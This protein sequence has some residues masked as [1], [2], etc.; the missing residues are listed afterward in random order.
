[1]REKPIIAI[2]GPPGSGKTTVSKMVANKLGYRLIDTGSM[3]RAAALVAMREG[4]EFTDSPELSKRLGRMEI[5]FRVGAEGQRIIVDGEDMEDQLRSEEVGMK[6]S[7]ISRVQMVRQI[8]VEKQQ[9][10]GASGGVICEG[11]DATTV[12]F[13]DAE[14][15]FFIDAS[16]Y[17]RAERRHRELVTAGESLSFREAYED[18][19]RRDIQDSTRDNSPLKIAPNVTCV[20][21][22]ALSPEEAA[23]IIIEEVRKSG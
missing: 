16:V 19:I 22:T 9:M 4:L 20:D 3:Y 1:M 12:I 7:D 2:D 21:T 8:L 15:K 5:E 23:R 17:T 13:P 11:R 10:M 14:F 18:M 6:A